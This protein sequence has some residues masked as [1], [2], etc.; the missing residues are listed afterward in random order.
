MIISCAM[1]RIS[2]CAFL[3]FLHKNPEIFQLFNIDCKFAGPDFICML[4]FAKQV[5]CSSH[6][7][8]HHCIDIRPE[9]C[10]KH[11]NLVLCMLACWHCHAM[12]MLELLQVFRGNCNVHCRSQVRLQVFYHFSI[13]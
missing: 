13:L 9:C 1:H 11:P 3:S 4:E 10:R 12:H 5:V 7:E 8:C 6:W 2:Q